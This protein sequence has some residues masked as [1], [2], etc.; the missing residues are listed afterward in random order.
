VL[1][2]LPPLTI[3]ESHLEEGLEIIATSTADVLR[4]TGGRSATPVAARVSEEDVR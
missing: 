4:G 1:K 3:D 2:L